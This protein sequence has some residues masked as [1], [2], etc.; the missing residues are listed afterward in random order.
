MKHNNFSEA[1]SLELITS[2]IKDSRARLARNSGTPFLVWGYITV[3]VSIFEYFVMAQQWPYGWTWMWFAIP[4]LGWPIMM[5]AI[6]NQEKGAKNHIDRTI[7]AMWWVLGL[8]TIFV[9]L[10]AAAYKASLFSLIVLLMGIGTLIT[11]IILREKTTKWCGALAMV[12][13]TIFPLRHFYI[14]KAEIMGSNNVEAAIA[15]LSAEILIFATIFF[16]MMVVPGHILNYKTR[17]R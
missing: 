5:F 3:A 2:M 8:S 16:V 14:Y 12:A 4:I 13:S 17:K 9:Y 10:I 15:Y 6:R 11:G 7:S 1:E